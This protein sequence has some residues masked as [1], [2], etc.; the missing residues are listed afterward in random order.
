M[1]GDTAREVEDIEREIETCPHLREM[2][3]AQLRARLT[4]AKIQRQ[5]RAEAPW[6]MPRLLATAALGLG[7]GILA[8]RLCIV[9][10]RLLE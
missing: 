10:F 2:D 7:L 8:E 3:R 9:F 5:H 4:I 1:D 6:A